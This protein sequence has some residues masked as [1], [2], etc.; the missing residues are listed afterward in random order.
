[1]KY[2]GNWNSNFAKWNTKSHRMVISASRASAILGIL[3]GKSSYR[4]F[5]NLGSQYEHDA[6]SREDS[7]KGRIRFSRSEFASIPAG[8]FD[9][10][11]RIS[12]FSCPPG[13]VVSAQEEMRRLRNLAG[14]TVAVNTRIGE[15][16]LYLEEAEGSSKI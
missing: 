1:M 12:P 3:G 6:S 13:L 7:R 15:Q 11:N 14:E 10:A 4:Y 9:P 5:Q 16:R 2:F 8:A